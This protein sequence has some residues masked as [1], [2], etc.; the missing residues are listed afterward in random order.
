[1]HSA[2]F[3]VSL[4]R[5]K[6][7]DVDRILDGLDPEQAEVVRWRGD[8]LC[9]IAGAGC[10]KTRTVAHRI[11]HLN[12][13]GDMPANRILAVTHSR[14]AAGELRG[15]LV[16]LGVGESTCKTFHSAALGLVKRF[17]PDSAQRQ[18]VTDTWAPLKRIIYGG[19]RIDPDQMTIVSDVK[20]EIELAQAR[21]E[22]PS[23]IARLDLL[24]TG[25]PGT[26]VAKAWEKWIDHKDSQ[27]LVDFGDYLSLA[28]GLIE[29]DPS[30]AD[31]VHDEWRSIVVDEY[32]DIDPSQQAFL[33]AL[34]GR[35]GQLCAVG[36]PRQTIFSFKG[37]EPSFL[38]DFTKHWPGSEVRYLNRNYRS[39]EQIVA[40][41]NLTSGS[42]GKP[43]ALVAQQGSGPLP[44][45]VEAP[46]TDVEPLKVLDALQAAKRDGISWSEMAVLFRLNFQSAA[47]E[48][49][50]RRRAIPFRVLGNNLFYETDAVL[51]IL[52]PF[53][54]AARVDADRNGLELLVATAK[55]Q[56]WD[57]DRE[58]EGEG[59]A[60]EKWEYQSTLVEQGEAFA[61]AH[62]ASAGAPINAADLRRAFL[63]SATND[64][65]PTT[66]AVTL[67][68]IHKAKGLEWDHVVLY[69][70]AEGMLPYHK[71]VTAGGEAIEEERRLF[72]VAITRA[73]QRLT[74]THAAS[75]TTA[76]G[77]TMNQERSSFVDAILP[78]H[79]RSGRAGSGASSSSRS[80]NGRPGGGAAP[81]GRPKGGRGGTGARGS[82]R[83]G[84]R[85]GSTTTK[86]ST[87]PTCASCAERLNSG[88]QKLGL[89]LYCLMGKAGKTASAVIEWRARV[90]AD[91]GK[92]PEKVA[93]DELLAHWI[94]DR[95]TD[96]KASVFD[97]LPQ[98]SVV[99]QRF[100]DDLLTILAVD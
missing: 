66:D 27:H 92:E 89:H 33:A 8:S 24:P 61:S 96:L 98:R 30:I 65:E 60:H 97:K 32:Q 99:L 72:Y 50:L 17:D 71:A 18:L 87:S 59:A 94:A 69:G 44:R 68:T 37:S 95:P 10:G 91:L 39:T 13:T 82:S 2:R 52:R 5:V 16:K 43:E 70:A 48:G 85:S 93:S 86:R 57:P 3:T 25:R 26:Q 40:A 84:G 14:K 4:R 58:P 53:G 54:Q 62:M 77:W 15:R 75:K 20:S 81:G 29:D 47:L 6:T 35:A 11:A 21:L 63:E 12:A 28:T 79:V 51:G 76:K 38:R 83:T 19:K 100:G 49:L 7:L 64:A 34:L 56:G 1:M 88:E 41:A 42:V 67:A 78:A 23:S 55:K 9:V 90:A 74:I 22:T 45:L 31:A 46:S 36:D 73:R 80:G